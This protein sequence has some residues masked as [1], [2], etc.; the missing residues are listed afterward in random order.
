MGL[1][2]SVSIVLYNSARDVEGCLQALKDQTR[3]PDA[4]VVV[5]NASRDDGLAR[6][7]RE[8]PD[9]RF[10]R[11]HRNLGFAAAQNRAM[12]VAPADVHVVLNPDCRLAPTFL[13]RVVSVLERDPTAG[14]VTGRL[15]RFRSEEDPGPLVECPDDRLDSTG[16]LALRNRR[17]L[18]R[19]SDRLAAGVYLEPGYVFG[20]SGAAAVYRRAMLEDIA[21]DG[22]F[23]DES[24][25]AY[26]ED[27]DLA[28]RAQLLGWRCR[29]EPSA[30][31]R[32]RRFVTP[33]RR[34]QLPP[35]INRTSVANRWRLIAK[36][37]V[38][39]GWQLD[40]AH[41]LARDVAIIGYC[42]LRE[43]NTLRA[44]VDVV[45]DRGRL[46]RWRT[47]T[48]RRRR[49]SDAQ[50]VAWFGRIEQLPLD[51]TPQS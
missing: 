42:W 43:R 40:W 5:D 32:H 50:M 48:M 13:E 25:F 47:N 36:N 29:Y 27:V 23:F 51:G 24:F 16:M 2:V 15:L 33:E 26:R 38:P 6:A 12:A 28:W 37:E 21:C 49:V 34:R 9:G 39:L 22:Q 41:I 46:R 20:A 45:S 10:L 18:D 31:A 17:V 1:T 7:R 11:H 30:L 44:L 35:E 14:S 8:L 19:G 3:Q 4:V